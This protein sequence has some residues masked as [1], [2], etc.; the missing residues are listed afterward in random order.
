MEF[1][2]DDKLASHLHTLISIEQ[3]TSKRHVKQRR[4]RCLKRQFCALSAKETA[5]SA[6]KVASVLSAAIPVLDPQVLGC[7]SITN[8]T[9][10]D[11]PHM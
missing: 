10:L 4:Q 9:R 6:E 1:R 7:T 3:P 11:P 5:V 8:K 2:S